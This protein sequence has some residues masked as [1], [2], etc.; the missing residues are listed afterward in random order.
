MRIGC[1]H[2]ERGRLPGEDHIAPGIDRHLVEVKGERVPRYEIFRITI[3]R[4][5]LGRDV[6]AAHILRRQLRW[7]GRQQFTELPPLQPARTLDDRWMG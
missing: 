6:P 3:D 5:E 7:L 4:L 2:G 1:V